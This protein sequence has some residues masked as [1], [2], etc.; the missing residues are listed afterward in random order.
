MQE[1]KQQQ[2]T[3]IT[4]APTPEIANY[5]RRTN[6]HDDDDDDAQTVHEGEPKRLPLRRADSEVTATVKEPPLTTTDRPWYTKDLLSI[7][8]KEQI[9][10]PRDYPMVKKSMIL[11]V[12]AV[13]GTISPVAT[14]IYYPAIVDM[15]VALN[16]TDTSMNASLS[17]F[18]FVT[19]FFPLPW[20]ML[21]DRYGRRPI[22]LA[23]FFISVIGSICCAVSVNI[24]MFIAFRA[25]S[26]IGSSSVMSMGA[27]TIS[28]IFEPHQRGRAFA[29]YTSGPLLGPAIAPIIGGYLNEGLGWRSNF[30]FLAI[31]AFCIWVGIL[32]VL[33]ETWRPS[34]KAL[35]QQ[36]EQD[37]QEKQQQ[38]PSTPPE[39]NA[40]SKTIKTKTNFGA[41]LGPLQLFRFPN[42]MLAISFVGILFLVYYLI[43][44]NFT[45]IYTNQYGLDSGTVGLCYLPMAAGA[46]IGGLAGGKFSD[47]TYKKR[48]KKVKSTEEIRAEMRLGG[49]V[50]YGS[51]VLQ[52]FAFIAFGWCIEKNVHYGV[53][54][55]C[56]FFVG[57]ALMIPNV[58]VSAYLV[59][60]FS[61]Q[62]AA[63]TACNN[64][65][66][67][68]MAGIGSLIA[69]DI[70]RALGT[71]ILYTI[72]G[73]AMLLISANM[74]AI[75]IYGKKWAQKRK[76]AGL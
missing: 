36:K 49:P 48:V 29:Y 16:T 22:Y 20:S 44:T 66:R 41:L 31:F 2:H 67:Y 69:S 30:W 70:Q 74:V 47:T 55:V 15:Q 6:D 13:A 56:L 1:H 32:L 33:P 71:G 34:D 50:F 8:K 23:S 61:K 5:A 53:G 27:G 68:I 64:F 73:A 54:L 51:L 24:G 60:C 38:G 35:F 39:K 19:A 9:L 63:V 57:L 12:V 75:R 7:G 58:T 3:T 76:E 52:L 59:D 62:G 43:N 11:L 21:G 18:T 10:D 46:I 14:T 65:V 45:R 26:A 28:D 25:I 4:I 37:I 72:C 42:I 17:V 40:T